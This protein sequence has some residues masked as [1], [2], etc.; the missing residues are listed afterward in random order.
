MKGKKARRTAALLLALALFAAA[1]E[2]GLP[3]Q[4]QAAT[5]SELQQEQKELAQKQKELAAQLDALR[6]DKAKQQEY[7]NALDEQVANL[8][9]QIDG[10]NGQ[11]S[12]LDASI[13]E[14]SAAIAEKQQN[15]DQ[16]VEILKERLCALYMAGEASNLE[17]ILNSESVMDMA[18]KIELMNMITEHDTNL[19]ASLSTEMEEI[20]AEKA[21]I[22]SQK[23]QV[24]EA[25]TQLESKSSELQQV[26]AEA[27]RVL[28]EL[29]QSVQSVQAESDRIAK[30]KEQA[31]AEIDQWWKDYYAQ[32]AAQSGG[33]SGSS[34]GSS[35]SG[36]YV[37]TGNF[38]WPVPGFTRLTTRFQ[39]NTYGGRHRGI[40]IA[41]T[42]GRSIYGAPI[43]AADSGR[44]I[45][46]GWDNSYGYCVYIDHGGGYVPRYAHASRLA[47]SLGQ[48]V[49]KGQTIA[50]VG[51]TGD[52]F[53]A[54]CHFEVILNGTLQNPM[55]YFQ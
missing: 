28:N 13:N 29:N 9:S 26:Q 55:N 44:V 5:L 14:K 10:L 6:E 43:V 35:G 20:S 7:K 38:T 30:E 3:L 16:N 34:G 42:G 19:I 27:E 12:L 40:D 41:S 17:I 36:G 39:E 46:A 25:K 52:S 24:A 50:Y 15:I 33:S 4:A 22:E 37:S 8:Q 53:G 48:T 54:H 49:T 31:S 2:A 11:I 23:T 18:E 32:Q 1:P 45:R 51:N 47:V 21:E